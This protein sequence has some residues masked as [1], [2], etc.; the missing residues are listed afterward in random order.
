LEI[1]A[2]VAPRNPRFSP[3]QWILPQNHA[4]IYQAITKAQSKGPSLST[5]A[6]LTTAVEFYR[7]TETREAILHFVN[8]DRKV[9]PAPFS[10]TVRKQF[11]GPVKSVQLFSPDANDPATLRFQESGDTVTFTVPATRLY[12]MLVIAS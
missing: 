7:R 1:T 2:G 6:P 5:E 8:F 4:E 3:A 10:A 11:P 12:S 9:K